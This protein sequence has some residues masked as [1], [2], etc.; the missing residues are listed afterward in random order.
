MASGYLLFQIQD[1]ATLMAAPFDAET[2]EFSG[3]ALPLA[4]GLLQVGIGAAGNIGVSD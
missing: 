3:P 4:E 1:T 2:L